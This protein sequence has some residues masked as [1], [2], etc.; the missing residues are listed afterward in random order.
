MFLELDLVLHAIFLQNSMKKTQFPI[1]FRTKKN[2]NIRNKRVGVYF[3]WFYW[4]VLYWILNK[5]EI[6][7]RRRHDSDNTLS[8]HGLETLSPRQLQIAIAFLDAFR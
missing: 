7:Y 5:K 3:G 8:S 2:W 6:G 4:R 1:A